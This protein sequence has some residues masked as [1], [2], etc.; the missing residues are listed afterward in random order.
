MNRVI[1]N[2]IR[3]KSTFY[4]QESDYSQAIKATISQFWQKRESGKMTS[5]HGAQLYWCRFTATH[6]SKA[7]LILNGRM[8]SVVKYQELFFDLFQQGFDIYSYDHQGQ[9]LSD[10][11]INASDVGHIQH[12]DDYA[13]DTHS[14]VKFFALDTYSKCYLLAHSMGGAIAIRYLQNHPDH[15]FTAFAASAP[16]LGL[17]VPTH[18][19]PFAIPYTYWLSKRS[20]HPTYAPGHGPY[21]AKPFEDNPLSHSKVRYQ[22]FRQLYE[23]QPELQLGGPSSRWVW[24]SLVALKRIYRQAHKLTIPVLVLQAEQDRIIDNRAQRNFVRKLQKHNAQA[25]LLT[26]AHAHHELLF[27]MDRVRNKVLDTIGEFFQKN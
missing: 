14:M 5:I 15:P 27:E 25:K 21:F 22:W 18:L 16:M 17:P 7:L 9:G 19:R 3:M 10:R 1:D 24:Q 11:C 26:F 20:T 23:Q 4:T 12:F 6:H 13:D 2:D 8:E